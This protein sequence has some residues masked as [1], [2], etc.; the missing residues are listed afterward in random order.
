M[1]AAVG[2]L[3]LLEV[4]DSLRSRQQRVAVSAMRAK[5]A[6]IPTINNQHANIVDLLRHNDFPGLSA[7]LAEHLRPIPEV[8]DQLPT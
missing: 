2:N 1:V 3:V 5:P 4:Y 7:A 8:L 6:R